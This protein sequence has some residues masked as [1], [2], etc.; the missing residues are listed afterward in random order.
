MLEPAGTGI[1]MRLYLRQFDFRRFQSRFYG[2]FQNL[3]DIGDKLTS[4]TGIGTDASPG[5]P[6]DISEPVIPRETEITGRI[7]VFENFCIR[8]TTVE[9]L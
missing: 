6:W 8:E 1:G 5:M 3:D 4:V 2:S 7:Q 9:T